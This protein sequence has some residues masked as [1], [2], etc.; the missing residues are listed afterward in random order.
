MENYIELLKYIT[1]YFKKDKKFDK[2]ISHI[3]NI[4]FYEYYYNQDDIFHSLVKK[5]SERYY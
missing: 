5:F 4:I 3:M 1:K 2:I